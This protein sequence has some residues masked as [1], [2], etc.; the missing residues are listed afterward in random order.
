M[1]ADVPDMADPSTQIN[2]ALIDVL[3][4]ADVI[5]ISGEALSHC[6]ANTIRDTADAFGDD[7]V[8]KFVLLEDTCSNVPGFDSLGE[9]FV[10]EMVGRGMRISNSVDFLA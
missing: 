4:G 2:K 8:K 7:N 3:S 1:K 5:A 6:V 9:D 10:K